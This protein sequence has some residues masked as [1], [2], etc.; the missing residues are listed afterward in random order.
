MRVI[1]YNTQLYMYL[2]ESYILQYT[3]IHVSIRGVSA[4]HFSFD[5][6]QSAQEAH[7][8]NTGN[9]HQFQINNRFDTPGSLMC[10]NSLCSLVP[11]L[12]VG[13]HRVPGY[14]ATVCDT[15]VYPFIP[16]HPLWRARCKSTVSTSTP[17]IPII[18][19][20][21]QTLYV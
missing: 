3:T 14:E 16:G 4:Q 7:W 17:L 15:L 8:D 20:S 12:L 6:Q 11:R 9:D 2:C 18:S 13:A 10:H 19:T 21:E 1:S 5:V